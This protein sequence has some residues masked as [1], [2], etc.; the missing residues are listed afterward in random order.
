MNDSPN[1]QIWRCGN[2]L[3]TFE[4][5]LQWT[6][7]EHTGDPSIRLCPKCS[8]NVYLC[9]SPDEFAS[10]AE[11]KN[12]V[13]IPANLSIP[14]SSLPPKYVLGRPA[15]WSYELEGDAKGFW[16]ELEKHHRSLSSQLMKEHERLKVRCQMMP[17]AF[18]QAI[19]ELHSLGLKTGEFVFQTSPDWSDEQI[20]A[21]FNQARGVSAKG[22]FGIY[23]IFGIDAQGQTPIYVGLS[24]TIKNDG[25]IREQS[26]HERLGKKQGGQLRPLFFHELMHEGKQNCGPWPGGLHFRW[27]ETYREMTGTPPFLAESQLLAAYLSDFGCLPPLNNEA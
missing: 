23:I 26:L 12:C 17:Q 9:R 7:L 2:K 1:A 15:P 3:L 16:K 14:S 6:H 24:G 19:T 10:H 11:K 21:A 13:A 27:I 25:T 18:T 20:K 4:C 5:P 22:C 8:E